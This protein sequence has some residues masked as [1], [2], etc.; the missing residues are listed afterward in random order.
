MRWLPPSLQRQN[1]NATHLYPHMT[2]GSLFQRTTSPTAPTLPPQ[3]G[4]WMTNSI[5]TTG[6]VRSMKAASLG[7]W[8]CGGDL[9]HPTRSLPRGSSGRGS[10][11]GAST[12][13]SV[14]LT[15]NSEISRLCLGHVDEV[16]HHRRSP[17]PVSHRSVVMLSCCRTSSQATASRR[18][19]CCTRNRGDFPVG[20]QRF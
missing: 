10:R 16:Q 4:P 12:A 2:M 11:S 14:C 20:G 13:R 6:T 8:L 3:S 17:Q 15:R 5:Q 1:T 7:C 19:L 18:C 9:D